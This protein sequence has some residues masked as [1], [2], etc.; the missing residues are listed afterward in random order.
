MDD[1]ALVVLTDVG[2]VLGLEVVEEL[3]PICCNRRGER[4]V[5]GVEAR[6]EEIGVLGRDRDGLNVDTV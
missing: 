5:V 2:V 3:F 4:G 6:I 1:P